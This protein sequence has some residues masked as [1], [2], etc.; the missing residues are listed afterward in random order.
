M[1]PEG[2]LT[3]DRMT[4]L[5][6]WYHSSANAAEATGFTS[7]RL[8]QAAKGFGLKFRFKMSLL[9]DNQEKDW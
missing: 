7:L 3:K 2:R 9:C 1:I 8:Q 4:K 5:V 6:Y